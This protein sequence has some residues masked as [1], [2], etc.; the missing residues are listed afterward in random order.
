MKKPIDEVEALAKKMWSAYR[1]AVSG[2]APW[3]DVQDGGET[4]DGFRAVARM[5]LKREGGKP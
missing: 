3:D 4:H 1:K 5:V 2:C